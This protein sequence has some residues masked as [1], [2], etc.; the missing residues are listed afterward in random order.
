MWSF[1]GGTPS[2]SIDEN[3]VITYNS[4]GLFEVTLIATDGSTN[5]ME[6]KTGYI[7]VLPEPVDLPIY[8]GFENYSTLTDIEEWGV[9]NIDNNAKFE[10]ETNFGLTGSKSV[11]LLNFGQSNGSYD[12]L[13][14]APIDLSTLDPLTDTLTLSFRYAYKRKNIN[15]DDWF[16]VYVSSDCGDTWNVRRTRHGYQISEMIQSSS[17]APSSQADW[18]TVHMVNITSGSWVENF[19]Y[20]F[21]FEG[22][23][24][25]N[26]YLD[27]I[28]IYSGAPSEEFIVGLN[29]NNS[30]LGLSVYPNPVEDELSVKFEMNSAQI[31]SIQ[32][33]G[34]SGKIV[35]KSYVQTN[36]GTNIIFVDTRSLASG[37]YFLKLQVN[38]TD[39][40]VQFVVE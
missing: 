10:L 3:P 21:T 40:I 38:G 28:N 27:D 39:K 6:L 24:G 19:K 35:Q 16:R 29:N 23:G 8:D 22:G 2:A 32:I 9:M 14:A 33:Q 36:E 26:F 17:F 31:A 20:K 25:N 15:D 4:P 34:V 7:R 11:R 5:D 12:E 13:I 37:M 30:L 18:V 1:T